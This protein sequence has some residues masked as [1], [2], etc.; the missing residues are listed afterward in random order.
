MSRPRLHFR[1]AFPRRMYWLV[2]RQ[3]CEEFPGL[4]ERGS[5]HVH[6]VRGVV[7][8][9]RG[10][11]CRGQSI[12][13]QQRHH[14][15]RAC[16]NRNPRAVDNRGDI[17]RMRTFHLERDNRSFVRRIPDDTQRIDRTK[18]FVRIFD[19]RTLMGANA[20]LPYRID[21][22]ERRAEPDRLHDGRRSRLESMRWLTVC[23]AVLEHLVDHLTATIE[24]RHF[25]EMLV[26]TV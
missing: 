22:I 3:S 19:E 16:T 6:L 11:A 10:A 9:E 7:H 1:A 23:N 25:G 13:R 8:A 5:E 21:V 20:H 15:M 18:L 2:F 24:R 4:D 12:T 26:F 17:V 14:A